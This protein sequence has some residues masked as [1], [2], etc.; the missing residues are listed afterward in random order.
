MVEYKF[1]INTNTL[2]ANYIGNV[3]ANEIIDYIRATKNNTQYP[4]SLKIISNTKNATFNFSIEELDL[5]VA[6]NYKS[7]EKYNEIIDAIIV[8]DPKKTVLTVL[9]KQFFK[10]KKYKFEIF[11]TKDAALNWLTKW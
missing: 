2:E 6:E 11:A 7:L 5:I 1:N 9:Y 4:R 10:T 8:D 3:T